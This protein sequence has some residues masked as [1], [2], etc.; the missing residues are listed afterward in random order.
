[1]STPRT[2]TVCTEVSSDAEWIW[3]AAAEDVLPA[4][5]A[6]G[7][8][9]P[10]SPAGWQAQARS[11][12]PYQ[13]MTVSHYSSRN[14]T[15]LA[16]WRGHPGQTGPGRSPVT[17]HRRAPHWSPPHRHQR[18]PWI[19]SHRGRRLDAQPAAEVPAR[20]DVVADARSLDLRDTAACL[21]G[22]AISGPGGLA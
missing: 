7:A 19:G 22:Q 20:I 10:D 6:A 18:L 4:A 17:S 15:S 5:V 16:S 11:A 8:G 1:M 2:K 13:D 12:A 3:R 21:Q 14:V 9:R